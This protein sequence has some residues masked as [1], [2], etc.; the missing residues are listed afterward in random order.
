MTDRVE[1]PKQLAERV[2]VNQSTKSGIFLSVPANLKA[3]L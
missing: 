2:G 3:C 1:T